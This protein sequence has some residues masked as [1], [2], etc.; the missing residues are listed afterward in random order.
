MK[1]ITG[2]GGIFFKANNP[3]K[4]GAWYREHLGLEVEDF[5]GVTFRE[6]EA[7]SESA[8]RQ[9][10]TVWSPFPAD[11]DYFAP[12]EKPFMIN[13]RVADLDALLEKLRGDGVKV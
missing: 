10:Y 6:N 3:A 13:F 2:I 1:H 4:L 12:S 9:A 11:T 8:K 5:G 7:S